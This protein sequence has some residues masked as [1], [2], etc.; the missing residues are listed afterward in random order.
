LYRTLKRKNPSGTKGDKKTI[1]K[2]QDRSFC[3]SGF[4]IIQNC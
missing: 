1:D 3:P 4:F 2:S